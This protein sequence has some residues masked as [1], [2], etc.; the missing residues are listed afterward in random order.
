MKPTFEWKGGKPDRAQRDFENYVKT[1]Y[2]KELLSF[3]EGSFTYSIFEHDGKNYG[4]DRVLTIVKVVGKELT[5]VAKLAIRRETVGVYDLACVESSSMDSSIL[6][7]G[8]GVRLYEAY[9]NRRGA[10]ASS[11]GL[12]SGVSHLYH[13]L[14]DRSRGEVLLSDGLHMEITGW[15]SKAGQVFPMVWTNLG[16]K[17]IYDIE[18]MDKEGGVT[19]KD[20]IK[21][22][23]QEVPLLPSR[24][25]KLI[26]LEHARVIVYK[27]R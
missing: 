16:E 22:G 1:I 25:G 21:S 10:L 7:K 20:S 6:G 14:I 11:A 19:V 2:G 17:S 24:N 8:F 23:N 26:N 18:N 27:K 4:D 13:S 9:T 12:K 5:E 3:T 15:R